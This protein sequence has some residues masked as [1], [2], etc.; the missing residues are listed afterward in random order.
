L[1]T[2]AAF[3]ASKQA[4]VI[5]VIGASVAPVITTSALPSSISWLA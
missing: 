1:Q 2:E 4:T 3:S 5:G